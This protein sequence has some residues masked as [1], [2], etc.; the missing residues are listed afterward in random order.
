MGMVVALVMALVI[1][2][3]IMV[4]MIPVKKFQEEDTVIEAMATEDMV[5]SILT[6]IAMVENVI[7]PVVIVHIR[8]NGCTH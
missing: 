2:M 5:T 8:S 1:L 6:V 7:A 3:I 4:I